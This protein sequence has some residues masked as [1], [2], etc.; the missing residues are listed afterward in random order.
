MIAVKRLRQLMGLDDN[1][2]DNEFRNLCKIQHPNIVGLI[3]YCNE[4]QRKFIRHEGKLITAHE[5]ERV[6]CFEYVEGGNLE[7]H[8][9]GILYSGIWHACDYRTE[10]PRV[11]P[12]SLLGVLS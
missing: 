3:G 12:C 1:A 9:S 8:I 2:F 11:C 6:L 7:N 10:E 4:S 5:M